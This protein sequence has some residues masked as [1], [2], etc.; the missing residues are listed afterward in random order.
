MKL[1]IRLVT[2]EFFEQAIQDSTFIVGRSRKCQVVIPHEGVSRQHVQIDIVNGDVFVTD[3][4]STNGVLIDGE[5]IPQGVKTVYQTFRALSFGAV[6]NM[7]IEFETS[8]AS[9]IMTN[10]MLGKKYGMPAPQTTTN[11]DELTS[12]TKVAPMPVR[13]PGTPP[14]KKP[15]A[16]NQKES[17][18]SFRMIAVNILVIG[19]L[20]FVAYYFYGREEEYV[21]V[22]KSRETRPKGPTDQYL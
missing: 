9:R 20:I 3:L 10:P 2:G 16:R 8:E 1:S 15:V 11:P 21:P 5:R 17:N 22:K 7:Q 18:E 4:G 12:V 6:E 13:K 14:R 19:L